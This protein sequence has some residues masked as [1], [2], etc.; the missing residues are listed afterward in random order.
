[1]T[2]QAA[3]DFRPEAPDV[4]PRPFERFIQHEARLLDERRFR[5]WMA[6]FTA[7]GTYWVPAVHGQASPLDHVS[8][9]YDDRDLMNIRINRLEHPRIHVQTPPSR[10]VHMISNVLVESADETAG[11]YEIGSVVLMFES[12][13]DEQRI[14][15]GRQTHVLRRSDRS[16]KIFHKRVDLANCDASFAAIAVPI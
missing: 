11:E 1:M 10:C 15:A 13:G 6:L 8:L 3:P 2:A 7:D 16:L 12:R 9:F 14:F 4:D 5:E